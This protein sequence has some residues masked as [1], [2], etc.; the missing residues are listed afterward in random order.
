VQVAVHSGNV[1]PTLSRAVGARIQAD[2][3]PAADRIAQEAARWRGLILARV[4]DSEKRQSLLS[5]FGSDDLLKQE[6]EQPGSG[7]DQIR[8]QIAASFDMNE[9]SE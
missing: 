5:L 7:V 2:L 1:A 9:A 8:E 4:D 3:L 6:S